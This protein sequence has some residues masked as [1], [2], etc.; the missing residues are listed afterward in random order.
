[1]EVMEECGKEETR[2]GKKVSMCPY[3]CLGKIAQRNEIL[4]ERGSRVFHGKDLLWG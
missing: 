4:S 2:Q 1:M 3:L